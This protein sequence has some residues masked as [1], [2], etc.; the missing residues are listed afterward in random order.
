MAR[1][2]AWSPAKGERC[3][4]GRLRHPMGEVRRPTVT[5]VALLLTTAYPDTPAPIASIRC[6]WRHGPGQRAEGDRSHDAVPPAERVVRTRATRAPSVWM[7]V[8]PTASATRLPL[9]RPR[10]HP[11]PG[12]LPGCV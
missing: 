10:S 9:R 8:A 5:A 6:G 7:R 3:G 1:Q 11:V 2:E 4:S 12:P